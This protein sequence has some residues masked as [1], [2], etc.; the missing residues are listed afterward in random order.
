M[1]QAFEG[2]NHE[3][4]WDQFSESSDKSVELISLYKENKGRCILSQQYSL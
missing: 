3:D 2:T 1:E 4:G